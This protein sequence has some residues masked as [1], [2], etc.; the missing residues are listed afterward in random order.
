MA[1]WAR[2]ERVTDMTKVTGLGSVSIYVEDLDKMVDFYSNILGMTVTD[3]NERAGAAYLTANLSNHHEVALIASDSQRTRS[4]QI[5][6]TVATLE[7]LQDLYRRIQAYG[8]KFSNIVNHG[9]AFGC[10][11][12][13]PEDNRIEVYWSTGIDYPQP[14]GDPIDLNAPAS[15][16][17][18]LL[19]ELEPRA[20]TGDHH[21]GRDVGK[22]LPIS[23]QALRI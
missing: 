15:D 5:S 12:F 17:L 19:D 7:G 1:E 23:R 4:G 21:Y 8:C 18:K 16:L 9:I 14:Y 20:G 3:R 2:Q 11:F 22:R 10:Y 13:D 6:F